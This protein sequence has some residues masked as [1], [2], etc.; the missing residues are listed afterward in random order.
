MRRIAIRA[1]AFWLNVILVTRL[2]HKNG[3]PRELARSCLTHY[4]A[5]QQYFNGHDVC[6]LTR[7]GLSLNALKSRR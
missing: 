3:S 1:S 7:H 5:A 6:F 4:V 2:W